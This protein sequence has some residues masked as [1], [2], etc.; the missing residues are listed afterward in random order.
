MLATSN[1]GFASALI[2]INAG[3]SSWCLFTC[4]RKFSFLFLLRCVHLERNIFSNL[5]FCLWFLLTLILR[6][7]CL[8][9]LPSRLLLITSFYPV[10]R[11]PSCTKYYSTLKLRNR[12][13]S[14]PI[15]VVLHVYVF[16]FSVI[17]FI[18]HF[19]T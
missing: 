7:L 6:C 3:L 19:Q 16:V 15:V 10:L 12:R 2:H 4:G 8:L 14:T 5:A 17:W 13:V 11:S 9:S 18:F 1:F